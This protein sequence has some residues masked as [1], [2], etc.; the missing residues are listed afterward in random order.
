MSTKNIRQHIFNIDDN[1]Y[2]Y[3]LS[4]KS[5]LEWFLKDHESLKS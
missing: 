3:L 5:A 1:K 4:T 2:K